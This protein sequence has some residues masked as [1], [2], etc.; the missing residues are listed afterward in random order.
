MPLSREHLTEL[1]RKL[2]DQREPAP[3]APEPD[4]PPVNLA[5]HQKA[6]SDLSPADLA[7]LT[8]AAGSRYNVLATFIRAMNPY[9]EQVIAFPDLALAGAAE[10][11]D[12]TTLREERGIEVAG[13]LRM[14][15]AAAPVESSDMDMTLEDKQ[16]CFYWDFR[17]PDD[18]TPVDGVV[19]KGGESRNLQITKAV[20]IP[21]VYRQA[22]TGKLLLGHLLIG[23]EGA[24]GMSRMT[25]PAYHGAP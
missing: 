12:L 4:Q 8:T 21:F 14:A 17:F 3:K 23:Y 7:E 24:G 2:I 25:S 1:R 9:G 19:P 20:R 10:T 15:H 18:P 5:D 16:E 13:W 22:T 6:V 11:T